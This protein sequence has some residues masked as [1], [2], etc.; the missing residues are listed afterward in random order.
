M[1]THIPMEIALPKFSQHHQKAQLSPQITKFQDTV[2]VY[3][4]SNGTV[5]VFRVW[6]TNSQHL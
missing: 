3:Q 1:A 6:S 2:Q 5:S 4:C